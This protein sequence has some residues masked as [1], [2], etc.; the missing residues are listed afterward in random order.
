MQRFRGGLVFKVHSLLYHLTLGLREIKKKEDV[1]HARSTAV[2]L[3]ETRRAMQCV[4]NRK[5]STKVRL[6]FFSARFTQVQLAIP[7][8]HPLSPACSPPCVPRVSP[9]SNEHICVRAARPSGRARSG[10]G[11]GCSAIDRLR[12]S[13]RGTARAEDAQETPTQSHVSPS[14]LVYEEKY[15]SLLRPVLRARLRRTRCVG[16][17]REVSLSLSLSH[18]HTH[19]RSLGRD[20]TLNEA[21]TSPWTSPW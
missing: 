13:G 4:Q 7:F 15:Q 14:I 21:G 6:T 2:C 17:G 5:S 19:T 3:R 10:A 8:F 11:A 1:L 20:F 16:R 18:T 9:P 12:V